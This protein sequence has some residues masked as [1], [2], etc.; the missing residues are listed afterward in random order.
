ML[1]FSGGGGDNF[2]LRGWIY[3]PPKQLQIFPG[4]I[5]SFTVK[6]NNIGVAVSEILRYRP[7]S[8]YNRIGYPVRSLTKNHIGAAFGEII[9]KTSCYFCTRIDFFLLIN[10][11]QKL[12]L[13][14][15]L[16]LNFP[17][18]RNPLGCSGWLGRTWKYENLAFSTKKL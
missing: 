2:L 9:R 7:I 11:A 6:E 10:D 13:K 14:I 3:H 4:P 16:K 5:K 15:R 1:F 18:S 17:G 8:L 12:N